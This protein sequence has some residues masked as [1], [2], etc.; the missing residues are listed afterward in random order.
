MA[1]FLIRVLKWLAA[2]VTAY[3]LLF[4]ILFLGIIG[5]GVLLQPQPVSLEKDSVLVL[6]LGFKLTD[7]PEEDDMAAIIRSALE[8]EMVGSASLREVLDGIREAKRDA[9]IAG[10]LLTGNLLSDGSGGSFA[11]LREIR[12]AI[13]AFATDKPVWA[14]VDGDGLRDIYLKSAATEIIS[15]PYGMVDFRGLRAERLYLG[16]AFERI[17]VEVQVEAF[18]EF[19]TAAE[20]FKEA[21][22]SESERIQLS[23]LIEDIWAVIV[24]DIAQARGLEAGVLDAV[25]ENELAVFGPEVP[26]TGLSDRQLAHDE[27]VDF[28]A[29]ES[30]Y[31]TEGK[32]FRQ[33]GFLDYIALKAPVI[34]EMKLIGQRNKVAVIYAEGILVDGESDDGV[35]GSATLVKHLREARLDDSVKAVVL[36]INSPGGSATASFKLVREIELTHAE[37]P[38]VASMGG[39]ATSA[40]YMISAACDQIFTEPSTIT[41]SIGVVIMLPNIEQMADKL[42]IAFE[43]VETH[44]FAG[45]YSIGHSKT[46]AEMEQIRTLARSFYEDFIAIVS[47]GRDMSTEAV[48]AVA[49]GRVWSG[50]AALENGLA[51]ED[52]GLMAAVQRAADLAS[53]GDDYTIV[54]RPRRMTFEEQLEKF[55]TYSGIT[56]LSTRKQGVLEQAWMDVRAE[57]ERLGL[58]NDPLGQY[59]ILPYSLKIR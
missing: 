42:S 33:V 30:A 53:I 55:L 16:E 44:P 27:F 3:F 34:P 26:A 39:I 19:K 9:N 56:R 18:E 32:S 23:S 52:G 5:V 54:E 46:P 7:G 58:L 57:V 51:D 25:A 40:G 43:G 50:L 28:L 38:V 2:L 10:L 31:D 6:D 59:A 24:G 21:E 49:G 37:K 1:D 17:G 20:S 13:A 11:A 41:G 45:T 14:Y 15:N 22:M 12:R 35:V 47:D 36:R 4:L 48:R 29:G 8:G